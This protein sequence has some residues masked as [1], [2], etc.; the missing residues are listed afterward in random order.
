M[1]PMSVCNALRTASSSS[2]MNTVGL[3]LI[4]VEVG[5]IEALVEAGDDVSVGDC[6]VPIVPSIVCVN[7]EIFCRKKMHLEDALYGAWSQSFAAFKK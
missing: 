1:D 2:T 4:A 7:A 5:F 3:L 6:I